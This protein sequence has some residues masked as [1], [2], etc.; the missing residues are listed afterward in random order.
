[1][2]VCG[3]TA[4]GRCWIDGWLRRRQKAC[5]SGTS[6]PGQFQTENLQTP[7]FTPSAHKNQGGIF[8]KPRL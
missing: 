5:A 3:S 8:F 4:R 7:F 6:L 1:M 2:Y